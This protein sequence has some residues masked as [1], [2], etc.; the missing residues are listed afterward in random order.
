MPSVCFICRENQD[1]IIVERGVEGYEGEADSALWDRTKEQCGEGEAPSRVYTRF[2]QIP[3]ALLAAA[4]ALAVDL[5]LSPNAA[6]EHFAIGTQYIPAWESAARSN[7][8]EGKLSATSGKTS[9]R[10]YTGKKE[11]A[12]TEAPAS[13]ATE[14][15]ATEAPATEPKKK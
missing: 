13:P 9:K 7:G 2:K 15:P 5:K 14:A 10:F 1:E 6:A 3:S 4:Y 11:P 12:A 8:I